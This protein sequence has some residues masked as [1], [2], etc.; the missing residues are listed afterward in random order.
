MNK[1]LRAGLVASVRHWR[2]TIASRLSLEAMI[3]MR[4]R[5][6]PSRRRIV[7]QLAAR[8][9]AS[10]VPTV[11]APGSGCFGLLHHLARGSVQRGEVAKQPTRMMGQGSVFGEQTS[12]MPAGMLAK[13][14]ECLRGVDGWAGVQASQLHQ[15][16]VEGG[17]TNSLYRLTHLEDSTRQVL[18]RIYGTGSDLLFDREPEIAAF[19]ALSS[20]GASPRCYGTFQGGR[21]EEFLPGTTLG[22]DEIKEEGRIEQLATTVGDFHASNPPIDGPRENVLMDVIAKWL[23][24]AKQ[25]LASNLSERDKAVISSSSFDFSVANLDKEYAELK[26]IIATAKSPIAFVHHDLIAGNFIDVGDK[27]RLIDFEYA[28]YDHVAMD[29]GNHWL[30]WTV[31]YDYEA[32]PHYEIKHSN[33]PTEAQQRRFAKAYLRAAAAE[34]AAPTEHEITELITE[35]NMFTMAAHFMWACWGFM[36]AGASTI[37]FGHMQYGVDRME[38]YAECKRRFLA[39]GRV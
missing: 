14:V 5:R 26:A 1:L 29:I 9:T 25:R 35:A 7:Y 10:A 37:E 22:R 38:M 39:T 8:R 11:L 27:V 31:N 30:E 24:V 23:A 32:Y 16:V 19:R 12:A 3:A 6:T 20:V 33:F 21:L 4:A 36:Q 28:W 17:L 34:G 13:V 18:A 2:N 15:T